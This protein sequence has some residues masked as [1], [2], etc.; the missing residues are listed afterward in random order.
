MSTPGDSAAT[1]T[2]PSTPGAR[3]LLAAAADDLDA[4]DT[5]HFTLTGSDLPTDS[6]ALVA[7]EGDASRPD[8]IAAAATTR[9]NGNQLTTN[10]IAIGTSA[11]VQIPLIG[12]WVSS[13][14]VRLDGAMLWDADTGV[15]ALLRQVVPSAVVSPSP[16]GDT[17]TLDGRI[18]AA[19]VKG[20]VP[21]ATGDAPVPV[22]VVLSVTDD[23]TRLVS[24]R[25]AVDTTGSGATSTYLLT[26]SAFGSPVTIQA[27]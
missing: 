20:L 8:R 2:P 4:T 7:A 13:D 3:D 10:V 18:P 27:P 24:V 11:W 15:A 6:T 19:A 5:V 23:S 1:T 22:S 9:S 14:N 26:L 16:G 12:T 21:T 17:V 25:V